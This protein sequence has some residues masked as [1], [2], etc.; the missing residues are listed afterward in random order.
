MTARARWTTLGAIGAAAMLLPSLIGSSYVLSALIFVGLNAIA[1]LGLTLVMGFAGQVSLGQAAFYAIGAYVS[2]VL[3]VSYGWN[4][5]AALAASVLAGALIALLV[6][7][8]IF[9]LSGLLLAMATL[10][11]GIIVY[12]VLVNWSA[13]TGGPSGLTGIPPLRI[14]PIRLDTDARVVRLVWICLLLLLGLT[15]NLMDS[16]VGRALRAIHGSEAAAQAAGID[17]GR[18][19]LGIFT[20]AGAMTALAGGLYAYYLAFV[21]PSPFGFAYSIELVLIVAV[22]GVGSLWGAPLGAAAVVGLVEGLRALL[23][24]LTTSHGAAEYEIVVFGLVLMAL[25]IALPQGLTGLSRRSA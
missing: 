11:F 2:G 20:L 13:V 12:Y 18:L 16:R 21:N 4:T 8:P 19:K 10:G 15:G 14:G 7:L 23:P 22:G 1:A 5:W 6:G 9:R 25:M 24:H 3:S 17:T